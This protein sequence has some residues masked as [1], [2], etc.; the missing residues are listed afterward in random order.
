LDD[1]HV[2]WVN[3]VV[4]LS[5]VGSVTVTEAVKVHPFASVIRHVYGPAASEE[6]PA[7]LPP[8]GLHAYV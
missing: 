2:A 1:P 3:E 4:A 5:A 8:E 7:A 6:A